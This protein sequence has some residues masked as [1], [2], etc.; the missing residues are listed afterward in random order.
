MKKIVIGITGAS[1]IRYALRMIDVLKREYDLCVI[2]TRAASL[3][4]MD[5]EGVDVNSIKKRYSDVSFYD[6]SDFNCK[7]ASG[8][9]KPEAVIICPCSAATLSSVANGLSSN[10]LERICDVALKEG[11]KLILVFRETP[12]NLIHVENMKR[13]IMAGGI[14]LPACPGFYNKPKSVEDM[15]DFVVAKTLN[16]IGIDNNLLKPWKCNNKS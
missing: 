6:E 5:E 10:L 16:R 13:V 11:I 14:I 8:S 12:L 2:Y 3:V 4:M 9:Q 7:Y 15:V 1:G